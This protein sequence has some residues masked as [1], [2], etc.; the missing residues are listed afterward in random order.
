MSERP[1]NWRRL[2]WRSAL[3]AAAMA[4]AAVG[5]SGAAIPTRSYVQLVN[6]G[7]ANLVYEIRPAGGAWTQ[8]TIA[9]GSTASFDC[10]DC[11][12]FE[13]R[14]STG[15]KAGATHVLQSGYTYQIFWNASQKVWDVSVA[16]RR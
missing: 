15:D 7:N 4:L 6:N 2:D 9:K 16:P 10:S 11:V 12:G 5:E 3:L 8:H 13:M 14:L 1:H